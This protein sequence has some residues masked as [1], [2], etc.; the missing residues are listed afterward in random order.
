MKKQCINV[1]A[2]I[3]VVFIV[4]VLLGNIIVSRIQDDKISIEPT[5]QAQSLAYL[6][7]PIAVQH[8]TEEG[9]II[10]SGGKF[11]EPDNKIVA[12]P[13]MHNSPPL[14]TIPIT[15]EEITT[16][17]TTENIV[18]DEPT[19]DEV[20]TENEIESETNDDSTTDGEEA[21]T[22]EETTTPQYIVKAQHYAVSHEEIYF[23]WPV[24]E[25]TD[26]E[27]TLLAKMLYCEAGG[28]GWDCQVATLSGIINHIEHNN[29]NF[30]VLDKGNHFSPASYY[31]YKTPTKMN[32]EVL[33][34]VLSGHLI[35]DVKY[36]QL[37][38]Y[39]SF[40]TPMF[41]ISG[42]YFSK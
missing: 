16:E 13:E 27:K 38:R 8:L 21:T 25:Y 10:S 31:R 11:L 22:I 24:R 14:A 9:A 19:T 28:E 42:V 29:G 39:H 18:L 26:E 35:A 40:G 36:F 23:T 20:T 41:K 30:G 17:K 12:H 3:G 4:G 2:I 37:Y 32:W 34:Y 6:E 1:V 7:N 33:D 5:T 15:N